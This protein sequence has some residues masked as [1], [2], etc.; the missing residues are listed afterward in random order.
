MMERI[1][2]LG[3]EEMEFFHGIIEIEALSH[4]KV[5]QHSQLTSGSRFGCHGD[6][7]RPHGGFFMCENT[8][9]PAIPYPLVTMLI[10]HV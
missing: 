8:V 3:Q 2:G 7:W 6:V 9:I 10:I 1:L 5:E 4:V